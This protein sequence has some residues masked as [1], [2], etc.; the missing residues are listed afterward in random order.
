MEI[1]QSIINGFFE[2]EAYVMLPF[3]ILI[4][5]LAVRMKPAEALF[6]SLKL[7]IGFA[8]VFL[9]FSHFVGVI[10]PAVKAIVTQ[11]GIDFPVLDVGWVP[12]AAIT[13][14]SSIAPISIL[15]IIAVNIIM[16]FTKTTRTIYID[17]WNYWHFAFL[18]ALVLSSTESIWLGLLAVILIAVY[19]IKNADWAAPYIKRE[20]NLEG[21]TIAPVSVVGLL[22]FAVLM[23][24]IYQRIPGVRSWHFNPSRKKSHPL[25]EFF[26]EPMIIGVL[27]GLLLGTFARYP[28]KDVLKV[29]I[30][31][32]AVMFL[33]PKCGGLI[34][35]GITQVTDR[36]KE[37][38]SGRFG[39]D[40]TYNVA[41]D[42]GIL[43]EDKSVIISGLLLMPIALVL[44]FVIPGNKTLPLG[45]LPNLLS[46]ISVTVM[47]SQGN[48]LR[49]VMT[50]IPVVAT[51][52][53]I[54]SHLAPL[55]TRLAAQT[56]NAEMAALAAEQQ[57]TAFT[58][59]GHQLRFYLYYLFQ[60]NLVALITI[61]VMIALLVFTGK[62]SAK[63]K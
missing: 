37:V 51:F 59:G 12:L 41:V 40:T 61:P 27:I 29:S 42:T 54:S 33:L 14:S 35:E 11:W 23:D 5:A 16:L 26:S 20:M 3:L 45:D 63:I 4:I 25:A 58:D 1:L 7:G 50:G 53:W 10:Q 55:F 30:N 19:T 56:S 57:I 9:V 13:W 38:I 62:Q 34:A 47:V 18:G 46:V 31:I 43:L 36:L 8:G 52:L 21:V 39:E 2:F 32:A 22:P 15:V 44:A 28:L 49:S 24:W 17:I 60:G 6:A 48:V